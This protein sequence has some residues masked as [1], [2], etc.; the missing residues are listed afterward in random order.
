MNFMQHA[1]AHGLMLRD[2]RADGRWHRVPTTD[3]PHKKNGAYVFDGQFGA[4]QNWATMQDVALYRPDGVE[5]ITRQDFKKMAKAA[6]EKDRQRHEKARQEAT[7]LIRE[8]KRG[9]HTYFAAKGFPRAQGLIDPAGDLIIPMRDFKNYAALNGFQ[10]INADGTKKFLYG[11]RAKGAVFVIGKGLAR[12][13]WL[14]EGYATGLSIQAALLDLRRQAEVIVCFSA[15][16]LQHVAS[17]VKRPAFVFADND[18]SGTGERVAKATGLPW[19][20]ASEVGTDANDLHQL[21]G[22]RA[23]VNVMRKIIAEGLPNT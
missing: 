3:H 20:M 13:R 16:N 5:R 10:R 14:V 22:L 4:V 12:E 23:L 6:E 19:G 17:M 18:E 15:A 8:C 2:V 9:E 21:Y 11:T 1:E 7:T